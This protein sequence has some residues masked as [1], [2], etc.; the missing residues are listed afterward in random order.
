MPKDFHTL[1]N[2]QG[3]MNTVKD[4]RDLK[5]E[6][7]V[8]VKNAM[9]DKQGAIRT[10]G[11][12]ST[13][14]VSIDDN[15]STVVGGYGLKILESDYETEVISK[16]FPGG[17]YFSGAFIYTYGAISGYADLGGSPNKVRV[18]S[19]LGNTAIVENDSI[20]INESTDGYDGVYT[21]TNVTATTFDI[22]S[23]YLGNTF[24][25]GEARYNFDS[26]FSVGDE[27]KITDSDSN[28]GLYILRYVSE[29]GNLYIGESSFVTE[30]GQ[31]P[32][33]EKLPAEEILV[34]LADADNREVDTFSKNN[35]TWNLE[36][37][38]IDQS[39]ELS[40][41]SK[42]VFYS[43]DGAI[44]TSDAN[45]D[46]TINLRWF[47][48]IKRKHFEDSSAI[49][50]FLGFYEK[51]NK[52][53]AP[54]VG[55][56]HTSDY[57]TANSGFNITVTHTENSKSTWDTE[58]YQVAFSFIYD[59]DQ[60]SLLYVPTADNVF[61]PDEGDSV[62][63][64]VRAQRDNDGYNPRIS[65]GRIYARINDTDDPWFLLCD[66]DMR[67]GT[68]TTLD[69]EPEPW[70]NVS[71]TTTSTAA[72]ESIS[73]NI[74]TYTTIN[75]YSP[76]TTSI[77][78]G[79]TGEQWKASVV[80]NRR[81]FI[82]NVRRFNEDT[83]SPSI[84]ADRIYYSEINKFD[85][86]PLLNYIDFVRGDAESY[87]A[88]EEYADR[89]LAFKQNSVQIINI[90]S[91]ADT[92]WFPE[93]IHKYKG[94]GHPAAIAKT[95]HGIVWVNKNGCY[96]YADENKILNLIDGKIDDNDWFDFVGITSAYKTIIGYEPHKKQL[97]VM[98]DCTGNESDSGDA[99]LF[100]FK[101]GAWVY[102]QNAFTDEK[103]YT[104][105]TYDWNGNLL[106]ASDNDADNDVEF[107]KWDDEDT[108]NISNFG[109]VTRDID[110]GSPAIQKKIYKIYITY[111]STAELNQPLSYA[112]DG[113]SSFTQIA[114]VEPE[115]NVG[116]AGYL[117]SS[118]N[119]DV[120][121]FT[122][123]SPIKLQSLQLQFKPSENC[124]IEIND[125]SIEYRTLKKAVT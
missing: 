66:I 76:G 101:T 60:E 7:S 57:P 3:G 62:S 79:E 92:N 73:K 123:A 46:N 45:F 113:N 40:E 67:R 114:D 108:S 59:G 31:S 20:V 38:N 52:L 98:R 120:A 116:G 96:L 50:P 23:A 22:E 119:W 41:S 71:E 26:L 11:G 117:E 94:V 111:K 88:L 86:F 95:E 89:L 35:D 77:S 58:T 74:D 6:E 84:F 55:E 16:T 110:F 33:I 17:I 68:R 83:A 93:D 75:G 10:V 48:Q 9:V 13:T 65:G 42:T 87:V 32:T 90:S 36:K 102:L 27:I 12:L 85:T 125:I 15:T 70:G 49:Q 91:P 81:A 97:I 30:S 29:N 109:L 19:G 51:D 122:L 28:D 106:I 78:L 25:Y 8:L 63:I 104:N 99:Y 5:E 115:G 107:F 72:I 112:V 124:R 2:F 37:I 24:E 21:A 4:P 103:A 47:G 100:D 61:T 69:S 121:T 34:L 18:T 39:G 105:F 118:N 64:V 80:A 54:T 44:R 82:A 14:G 43:I 1:N 53:S 56:I